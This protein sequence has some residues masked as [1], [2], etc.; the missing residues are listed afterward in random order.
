MNK[1]FKSSSFFF[2]VSFFFFFF[3]YLTP[4]R[5]PYF[6]F[7]MP[8]KK[9]DID[10]NEQL[11][12]SRDSVIDSICEIVNKDFKKEGKK[13]IYDLE[14]ED[15]PSNVLSWVST[16]NA[17]LD[18]A[19]SNKKNGGLPSGRIIEIH[20]DSSSG[21]SLL[22]AHICAETQKMGGLA[23][24]IDTE[25]GVSRDF[26]KV[27]GVDVKNLIY[28]CPDSVE[29]IFEMVEKI[30][31]IV[32]NS[33]KERQLTIVI[34]SI[35]GVPTKKE[36]EGNFD[37]QGYNTDK[38]LIIGQAMRKITN[39]IARKRIL[40]VITNQV[41]ERINALPFQDPFIVPAGK[42]IPFHASVRIRLQV[43]GTIKVDSQ[44]VGVKCLAKIIKN[45]LAPS[46]RTVEYEVYYDSGID[47]SKSW[48]A[49]LK[50]INFVKSAGAYYKIPNE[51]GE[52][53]QFRSSDWNAMLKND[54]FRNFIY[55]IMADAFIMKYK[56]ATNAAIIS[57]NVDVE[58]KEEDET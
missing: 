32:R 57:E 14:E 55:G 36:L 7:S 28:S 8:T 52:E 42:A 48:L 25:A 27:I 21:K 1:I 53:I 19:I 31:E 39:L 11:L 34:D 47:N 35:A 12:N 3:L 29:D 10:P 22:C 41:R 13:L 54:S 38:A 50:K 20:G 33:E 6:F 16:G 45:R 30:I 51:N 26:L 15:N 43:T 4:T 9:K 40:L 2:C 24:Y 37:K 17:L 18:L 46:N 23:V 5:K 49:F 44:V 56:N 58:T